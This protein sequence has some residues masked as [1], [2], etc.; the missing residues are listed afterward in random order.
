MVLTRSQSSKRFSV[1]TKPGKRRQKR[2][3]FATVAIKTQ[4]RYRNAR[5]SSSLKSR[6]LSRRRRKP[7]INE[8]ES[9]IY[10]LQGMF[11]GKTFIKIGRS[12]NYDRR[13]E[14]HKR[15]CQG[16]VWKEIGRWQSTHSHK[17]EFCIHLK[18]ELLGFTRTSTVCCCGTL[19]NEWFEFNGMSLE[20]AL[21]ISISIYIHAAKYFKFSTPEVKGPFGWGHITCGGSIANLESMWVA[22]NLKYYPLSLYNAMKPDGPLEFVASTFATML[23]TGEEKN[24]F[25]CSTWELLNLKPHDVLSLPETLESDYGISQS[26]LDRILDP[27]SIQTVG[28]DKLDRDFDIKPPQ[29]MLSS[30]NHYSWPKGAAILGIGKAN[31]LELRLDNDARLDITHLRETLEDHLTRKHPVYAVIAIMGTTEH[32][33]VDPLDKILEL[34]DEMQRNGM[35]FMVHADA[36]WG[37]YFA[38]KIPRPTLI[39]IPPETWAFSIPLSDYTTKQM[40]KLRATDSVTIDPHKSGYCPYPA[41]A[42]CYRDERMRFLTTW[43]SPV[44]S[45][46]KGDDIAMGIYGVEGSKPGAAPV[47]V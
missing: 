41:G 35:S 38:S 24:F 10:L 16:V 5:R 36:A 26:A 14:Q 25:S 30:S 37:G 20:K 43:T 9:D 4:K 45:T 11:K 27:Y 6:Y 13:L 3:N 18:L 44:L 29:I 34:R 39:G 19:H 12:T 22:R 2:L 17:A 8:E 1:A 31:M 21:E 32:G 40:M 33:S 28:K 42:L 15:Q 47:G 46:K 7:S 23:C